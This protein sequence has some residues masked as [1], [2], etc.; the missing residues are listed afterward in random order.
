VSF[1]EKSA[2][3][4]PVTI[5]AGWR[6]AIYLVSGVASAGIALAVSLAWISAEAGVAWG[7]FIG[8][9]SGLLAASN[10]TKPVEYADVEYDIAARPFTE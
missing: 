8:T 4:V 6:F 10:V 2:D 9:V 1:I 3:S 7:S 5:P